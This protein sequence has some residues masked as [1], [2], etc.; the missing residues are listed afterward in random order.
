MNRVAAPARRDRKRWKFR[1]RRGVSPTMIFGTSVTQTPSVSIPR[2]FNSLSSSPGY[3]A[4]FKWPAAR[5]GVTLCQRRDAASRREL[6]AKSSGCPNPSS[7]R[8][9][10]SMLEAS[11]CWR[12]FPPGVSQIRVTRS[13]RD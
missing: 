10:S 11:P 5:N 8:R 4:F 6:P 2:R 13:S 1:D 9:H 3:P 7:A 12:R